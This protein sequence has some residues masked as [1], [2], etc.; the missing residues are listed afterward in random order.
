M[1][2]KIIDFFKRL[3]GKEEQLKIE[4]PKGNILSQN[5]TTNSNLPNTNLGNS[6]QSNNTIKNISIDSN[7]DFRNN[8][9]NN[10]DDRMRL[11]NMQKA[12]K[13]GTLSEKDLSNDD[14]TELKKLYCEQIL[15]LSNSIE[16]Y[17]KQ[18]KSNG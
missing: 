15:E 11:L 9:I 18:I 13:A 17:T 5:Y 12:I 8:L 16:Y 14:I 2:K 1:I 7:N 3:F 4:A 10:A 6:L